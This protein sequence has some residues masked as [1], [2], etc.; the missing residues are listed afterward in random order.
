MWFNTEDYYK[1]LRPY[2]DDHEIDDLERVDDALSELNDPWQSNT[3]LYYYPQPQKKGN[4]K[5]IKSSMMASKDEEEM[6][7]SFQILLYFLFLV[8]MDRQRGRRNS[9]SSLAEHFGRF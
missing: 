7:I 3:D 1:N 8:G 5:E 4:L 9:A 2:S 6:P